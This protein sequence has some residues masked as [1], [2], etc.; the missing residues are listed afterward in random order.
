MRF[1]LLGIQRTGTTLLDT[2]LRSHP[3]VVSRGEVFLAAQ[4]RWPALHR[5]KAP[6]RHFYRHVL[7][8]SP[9]DQLRHALPAWRGGLLRRYLED[10]HR[11]E[12]GGAG[13]GTV[14]AVG[15]RLMANQAAALPDVVAWL[16]DQPVRVVRLRRR[17]LL[18][19]LISREVHRLRGR[20]QMRVAEA[21]P[22][23]RLEPS[24]LVSRLGALAEEDARAAA[25][26]PGKAG[27]EL[28]YEELS[29]DRRAEARRV[30]ALLGVSPEEAVE[31]PLLK[32]TPDDLSLALSNH[33]EVADALAGTPWEWCLGGDRPPTG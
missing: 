22:R 5:I 12:F 9:L 20:S 29:T 27:V 23:A 33:A 17:N 32:V 26:L 18:K 11:V 6:Q 16:E 3:A 8:R 25:L 19:T 10:L 14:G 4:H 21:V 15:F 2:L 24:D 30:F 7:A 31:T 1:V 28:A 13:S